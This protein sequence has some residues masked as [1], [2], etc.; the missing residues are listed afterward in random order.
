MG[1]LY[2]RLLEYSQ[3]DYYPYHMPGHKRTPLTEVLGRVGDIDITEIE[4]F[5]NL[6]QAEGL[7]RELQEHAARVYGTEESFYLVGGSTAG[8]L[9]GVSAAL[10][11][12][13]FL[14]MARNCHKA[15]YHSVYLNG[16]RPV[17][18]FPEIYEP[19]DLCKGVSPARVE[20]LLYENP[21]IGA[22]LIVSPTYEG[23]VSDIKAVAEVV[24]RSGI[25]LIVDE[26]HGAHLGF[27]PA[28]PQSACRQG[29]DLVIQS[30]HKT[31]P[32]MTQT[33]LLHVNGGL[34]DRKRLKRFLSIYQTSSPSYVFMAGME[35]AITYMEQHGREA[36]EAFLKKW[37]AM[38]ERL[39]EC[40]VLRILPVDGQDMPHDIGKLVISVKGTDISGQQL[41]ERLL[42]QYHLQM[43]LAAG[44][45]VL[46]MFTVADGQE[47]YDRLTQA[48][49]EIDDSLYVQAAGK[50]KRPEAEEKQ[51][52]SDAPLCGESIR[53]ERRLELWEAWDREKEVMCLEDSRGRLAGEF[54]NLYPP[55][56]PVLVPG[57]VIG[58]GMIQLI[59]RSVK[60][61]LPMQGVT[62]HEGRAY[63]TV[64][65]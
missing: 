20:E 61:G 21:Q 9:S 58:E 47:A 27:H 36:M 34:V 3:S 65:R 2:R 24:H 13:G 25:P 29:A 17:Y 16:L 59:D 5:D 18:L 6:H 26:A 7:L 55:G 8:I 40:R 52:R 4:G 54:V 57:E 48:V 41:Y 62:C 42:K 51:C 43:E 45:Y 44:T 1:Q 53:P 64:L 56:I 10:P 63:I 60:A 22:V 15:V 39:G 35:E 37:N 50:R 49:L 31:L 19:V 11:R 23:V 46:A 28:W 38:L 14:L 30:L 12:G 32:S 33:A